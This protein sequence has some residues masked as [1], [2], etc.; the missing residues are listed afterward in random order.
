MKFQRRETE[1][2]RAQRTASSLHGLLQHNRERFLLVGS[3]VSHENSRS[4]LVVVVSRTMWRFGWNQRDSA[5]GNVP[6]SVAFDL[7]NQFAIHHED[8]FLRAGVHVPGRADCWRHQISRTGMA[9]E[10]GHGGRS[11]TPAGR[12]RRSSGPPNSV[13]AFSVRGVR[14]RTSVA[15]SSGQNKSPG[16]MTRRYLGHKNSGQP[17]PKSSP[18]PISMHS[19]PPSAKKLDGL[20]PF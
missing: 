5:R 8:D 15:P 19:A 16:L 2:T 10:G 14:N 1:T 9:I 18:A 17:R 11:L 4:D 12:L 13:Q 3:T 20:Q 6:R 7:D